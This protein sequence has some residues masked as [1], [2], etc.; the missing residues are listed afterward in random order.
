MGEDGW[1]CSA[2]SEFLT[3]RI[4]EIIHE[5]I[6]H[7]K[8]LQSGVVC[9]ASVVSGTLGL[10]YQPSQPYQKEGLLPNC[11]KAMWSLDQAGSHSI[12][13]QSLQLE[14]LVS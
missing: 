7:F 3:H 11:S 2:Q 4:H 9:Y 13:S 8:P 5:I 6:K 12:P 14:N 1:S 10:S